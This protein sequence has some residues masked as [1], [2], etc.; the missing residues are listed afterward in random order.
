MNPEKI[1]FDYAAT[2]PVDPRVVDAMLPYFNQTFG[3]PSSVHRFGQKAE[4]ARDTAR[5]TIAQ[6]LNCQPN[7]VIFTSCG[8][9][10]DNLALRGAALAMREKTGANWI[11]TTRIEHHAVSHTAA[12]LE[13]YYGFRVEWLETDEFGIVHPETVEKAICKNTALVSIMWANNEIGSL[14][15]IAEIGAICR[16]HGIPFHSD[17]VQGS[18]HLPTDLQ[19]LNVDLLSI[20]AHKFYGP[21]GI[22]ALYVREGTPLIP[23]QTGGSQEFGF[24]AGTENIPY[25]VGTAEAFK[26]VHEEHQT[27]SNDLIPL[28]DHFINTVLETIPDVQLTGHPTNRL[29]NHTSFA[30]KNADAN[31]FLMM[32]D[33]EGF[34]CSSGSA[35]KTGDPRPSEILT[36][37]GMT[38]DWALGGLRVTFGKD[39]SPEEVEALMNVLPTLVERARNI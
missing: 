8:S 13:K 16:E 4:D 31:T 21:K 3:N 15:P 33:M 14:N 26:L 7:E 20:G 17:A 18:A 22:G 27:R 23:N 9:E 29:P 24:R 37:L 35:C 19:A 11:L 34:A 1:Y 30:F 28:R 6:A 32:L 2:T 5:E 38:A 39:T 36:Q 25:M 12:Q 10:S